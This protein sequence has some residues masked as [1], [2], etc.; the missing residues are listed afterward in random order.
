MKKS[1]CFL[2]FVFV[3]SVVWLTAV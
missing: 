1:I 3:L 2:S